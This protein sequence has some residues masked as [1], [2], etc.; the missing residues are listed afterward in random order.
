VQSGYRALH[1]A[2]PDLRAA[3]GYEAVRLLAQA[4][5]RG[6][7]ADPVLVA[8]TLRSGGTYE[9]LSGPVEFDESGAIKGKSIFIKQMQRGLFRVDPGPPTSPGCQ[10]VKETNALAHAM[11]EE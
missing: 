4:I 1:G 11:T 6:G 2:P 8:T 7:S 10:I 3:Q 5:E 9:G